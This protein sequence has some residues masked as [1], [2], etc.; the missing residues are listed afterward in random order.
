M[1]TLLPLQAQDKY[2]VFFTDK[3]QDA[4]SRMS[5]PELFLSA[6]ALSRRSDLGI[7]VTMADVPPSPAYVQTVNSRVNKVLFASRSLNAVAVEATV[8]Q[9]YSLATL[10]YFKGA[11][12]VGRLVSTR[13]ANTELPASLRLKTAD[14]ENRFDYGDA[15][16]QNNMLNIIPLHNRGIDGTGVKIAIFDA[17]FLNAN[18]I[19]AL[20]SAFSSGRVVAWHDFVDGDDEVFNTDSHGTQVMSC[21]GA[22]LPGEMIGMAPYATFYLA[23]T[24][25]SKTETQQE[26]HNWVAAAE[27]ADSIGV[28]I[29]HSSLGYYEFDNNVGDYAYED[30]NGNTAIITRAADWAASRGILVTSSA[31]NEGDGEWE[32]IT[33]PCDGDSVLCV[34]SVDS[35]GKYSSF[36]SIGPS[37]DGQVKPDVTAQGSNTT[38]ASPYGSITTS[39]GTS[40]S[41][42]I[43]AGFAACLIQSNP[44]RTNMEVI[45]AIQLSGDQ[46]NFPDEKYGYGIPNAVVADS[47][48][49]NV[50]DLAAVE[51]PGDEKPVRGA[52]RQPTGPKVIVYS[53]NPQSKVSVSGS[54]LSFSTTSSIVKVE[55]MKDLQQVVLDPADVKMNDADGTFNI[56]YLLDGAYYLHIETLDYEENVQF[57][58]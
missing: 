57:T 20:D 18:E 22:N 50:Q 13:A 29:I 15:F 36:S 30:M 42:P 21:I 46:Y 1:V 48:L 38:V 17:G 19:E 26:E 8:D 49:K 43:M 39:N 53:A 23:R 24:E 37:S 11:K 3:G 47:L 25:Q 55:I 35:R 14:D 4:L 2:W 31:G 40:F 34:G 44:E 7:S 54:T 56:Q 41:G 27:W 45:K 9:I 28:D 10:P 5:H 52:P 51:M 12:P 58:K 16:N 33:A 32:H 6:N